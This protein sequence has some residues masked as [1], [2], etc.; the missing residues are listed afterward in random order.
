MWPAGPCSGALHSETGVV[1]V[2]R[3][4]V[5]LFVNFS[6]PLSLLL[7][8]EEAKATS[9]EWFYQGLHVSCS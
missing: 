5:G 2:G 3:G 9:T 8:S 6:Y 7:D 1:S 4:I